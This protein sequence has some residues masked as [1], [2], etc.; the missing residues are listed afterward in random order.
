[1]VETIRLYR[2]NS[3]S[4]LIYW[5]KVFAIKNILRRNFKKVIAGILAAA[6]VMTC[7]VLPASAETIN[8]KKGHAG[9]QAN[10]IGAKQVYYSGEC[11]SSG[12]S[13]IFRLGYSSGTNII[14]VDKFEL[15]P[16]GYY[17]D[18]TIIYDKGKMWTYTV[19]APNNDLVAVASGEIVALKY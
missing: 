8:L 12:S 13:A 1:M 11:S 14:T 9:A 16:G 10:I 18:T 17:D 5:I 6:S 15:Y 7:T 19:I 4:V 2:R 3:V